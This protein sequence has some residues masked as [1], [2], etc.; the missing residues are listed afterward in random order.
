MQK[1]KQL[2]PKLRFS[3]FEEEWKN[4]LLGELGEIVSGLTYSP[5]DI[6]E[7]GTLVLR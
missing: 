4:T 3:E 1:E 5:K 7:D 6:H 2:V